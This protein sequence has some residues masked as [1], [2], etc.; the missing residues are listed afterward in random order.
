MTDFS[1]G[2]SSLQPKSS[3]VEKLRVWNRLIDLAAGQFQATADGI[4]DGAGTY[5]TLWSG[6]V[7]RNSSV[8]VR[9]KVVGRGTSR[10]AVYELSAGAQDFAGTASLI[11]GG[12]TLTVALEDAAAMDARWT[13]TGSLLALQV[14]D[15]AVQAMTWRAWVAAVTTV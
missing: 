13:L 6:T 1:L 11:G 12:F 8:A 7:P 14:R 4:S 3:D 15:D 2:I 10:G 5:L 9:A